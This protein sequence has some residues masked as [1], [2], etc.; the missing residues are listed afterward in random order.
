MKVVRPS[1]GPNLV[2]VKPP[3][4]IAI[5]IYIYIVIVVVIIFSFYSFF[6]IGCTYLFSISDDMA[7]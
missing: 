1:L 3:T 7:Y 2:V 5:Y 6:I 4:T